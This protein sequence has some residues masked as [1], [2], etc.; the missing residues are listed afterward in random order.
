[1]CVI[2]HATQNGEISFCAYNTG[3]GWRKIVESTHRVATTEDW[4]KENGRHRIYAGDRPIDLH[5]GGLAAPVV[6]RS[7]GAAAGGSF[8]IVS[9]C[10]FSPRRPEK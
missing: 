1:M 10:R 8:K 2:P 4:Y 7:M 6:E 9:D 5:P 3:V